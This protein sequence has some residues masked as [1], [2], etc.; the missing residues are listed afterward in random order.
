MPSANR[1]PTNSLAGLSWKSYQESLPLGNVFGVNYSNGTAS[2]LSDF[3]S[4]APLTSSSVVQAYAVKH[5]PFAYFK[6]VQDGDPPNNGL[7]NV[8][9][10]DGPH[11]LY[12]DLA[13]GDV[14]SL[15]FIAPNQCD[16]QH[17]RGD[18]DAFCA[19]DFGDANGF[20]G[21]TQAG[22]N[23]GLILQGDVT[24]E[25]LVRGILASPVWHEGRN[26][27]VIVW[28]ENDYSGVT[29]KPNG[30][31]PQA[32]QNQVVL[33][34]QTNYSRNGVQSHNYYNSFSLLKSMEAAFKLR[35]LNH[36]CDSSVS[37]MSDLFGKGDDD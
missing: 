5:N 6:S 22:L 15:A 35:C 1:L 7:S 34:V 10:F 13:T 2:N 30:L 12:V 27:I 8:V 17:G 18:S 28:D 33:T 21:G 20:T 4:L 32:N 29:T 3:T 36:T 16:D 31:F 25:R 14:P 23:P 24:I 37:V 11:G 26:A 9:G 19:F